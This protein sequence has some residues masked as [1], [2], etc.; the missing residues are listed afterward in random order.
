MWKEGL[1]RNL[2]LDDDDNLNVNILLG[3]QCR[4]ALVYLFINIREML[5]ESNGI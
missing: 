2:A 4:D 5:C 3:V 1:V